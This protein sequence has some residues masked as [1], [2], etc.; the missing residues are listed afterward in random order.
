MREWQVFEENFAVFLN[1]V[2]IFTV[3]IFNEGK[4]Y[5]KFAWFSVE[6]KICAFYKIDIAQD[7]K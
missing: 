4:T 1:R 6:W 5:L 2:L 3:W 7:L